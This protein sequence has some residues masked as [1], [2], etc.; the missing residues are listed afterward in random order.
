[1][2]KQRKFAA[3]IA[4]LVIGAVLNGIGGLTGEEFAGLLKVALPIFVLGNAAE[5][6][7]NKGA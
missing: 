5:H 1:M 7:F 4:T 6:Y 2:T 3:Y